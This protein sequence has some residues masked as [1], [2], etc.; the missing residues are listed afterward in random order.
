MVSRSDYDLLP[1]SS[2]DISDTE[3][4]LLEEKPPVPPR[5]HRSLVRRLRRCFRFC[6][7]LYI[8]AFFILFACWQL[9]FNG[10]YQSPK[11]FNIDTNE[12]VF[13]AANIVNGDLIRG[14]WGSS[15]KGLVKL[16]GEDKVFVSVYGSPKAALGEFTKELSCEKKIASEQDEPIDLKNISRTV[17]PTGES[18]IKRIAFLAEVRN[19]ALEPLR[20]S[21]K[22]FDKVLFINDVVFDPLEAARLLWGTN[23]NKDGKATYKAAC[24]ADFVNSWKYYDTFATRDAEGYSI[25]VPIFPWFTGKGDGISRQDVLDGKDAVRVKS[26]WGGMVA[27]DAR[28]F[29]IHQEHES[30]QVSTENKNPNITTPNLPLRF[31]FADE[32]FWDASE[33]CLVHA[34]L[35]ALPSFP[36]TPLSGDIYDTGIYMNP[37]VRVTYDI[38]TFKWVNTAKRFERLFTIPQTIISRISHMPY[39]NPRRAEI[40]GQLYQDRR[41]VKFPA[42]SNLTSPVGDA[43][44]GGEEGSWRR[45]T[46]GIEKREHIGQQLSKEYWEE[47]GFYESFERKAERGGY[48][49]TRQLLVINEENRGTEVNWDKLLDKVPP[50]G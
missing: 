8:L 21:D 32:A 18:R 19:R 48:C 4:R 16:I 15:L 2:S 27:F 14:D 26:C 49:G 7:P 35:M 37:F 9:F 6:R 45:R 46:S 47:R 36:D 43:E 13:I 22:K 12:R 25:G 30:I 11:P 1:R 24:A 31:R 20:R 29:Q 44:F 28:Y 38:S 42:E 10:S 5:K 50:L 23:V 3:D 17:L 41:W 40:E 33:C 39:F 34:D